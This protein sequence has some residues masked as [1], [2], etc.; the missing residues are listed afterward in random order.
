M[1][2]KQFGKNVAFVLY[3][4]ANRDDGYVLGS[5]RGVHTIKEKD[6]LVSH[7]KTRYYVDET[8]PGDFSE[9]E[10]AKVKEGMSV[11]AIKGVFN[12][13]PFD[14][15]VDEH[16]LFVDYITS[17]K[18]E[19]FIILK[20]D[21]DMIKRAVQ[22]FG[23]G[24]DSATVARMPDVTRAMR[25][26]EILE[27]NKSDVYDITN[28]TRVPSIDMIDD[29]AR[30]AL[31]PALPVK[32]DNHTPIEVIEFGNSYDG[33]GDANYYVVEFDNGDGTSSLK[34]DVAVFWTKQ[35]VQD[36]DKDQSYEQLDQILRT[37]QLS[38]RFIRFPLSGEDSLASMIG[39]KNSDSNA[40]RRWIGQ[41]MH[42]FIKAN[43]D[44]KAVHIWIQGSLT[45][46][47]YSKPGKAGQQ[48]FLR[49]VKITHER[50][51]K[52]FGQAARKEVFD[53][54]TRSTPSTYN[55][56]T[57]SVADGDDLLEDAYTNMALI[58]RQF[59][60]D[61][62][63]WGREYISLECWDVLIA[64]NKTSHLWD[65]WKA[66]LKLQWF[67]GEDVSDENGM[68]MSIA[69]LAVPLSWRKDVSQSL[70]VDLL[71][72]RLV[73][74]HA[75]E[76]DSFKKDPYLNDNNEVSTSVFL[77][78]AYL[79]SLMYNEYVI[80][81]DGELVWTRKNQC[82]LINLPNDTIRIVHKI[83]PFTGMY[84]PTKAELKVH[85]K[86]RSSSG[87]IS[88]PS[89]FEMM[90]QA[91]VSQFVTVA[92]LLPHVQVGSSLSKSITEGTVLAPSGAGKTSYV[93]GLAFYEM[94]KA[95]IDA[96]VTALNRPEVYE[97]V[98][99]SNKFRETGLNYLRS[100]KR[101]TYLHR[102]GAMLSSDHNLL[103][104][105]LFGNDSRTLVLPVL[106]PSKLVKAFRKLGD[107]K[108][109][110]LSVAVTK[111]IYNEA[112]ILMM[113]DR[114][115]TTLFVPMSPL[116][117]MF[118]ISVHELV[119]SDFDYGYIQ[120]GYGF[121]AFPVQRTFYGADTDEENQAGNLKAT[122]STI[123]ATKERGFRH[124]YE[125]VG[126]PLGPHIRDPNQFGGNTVVFVAEWISPMNGHAGLTS[127]CYRE[128]YRP[129]RRGTD[130]KR[131]AEL[132]SVKASG[133]AL[134]ALS[135][136]WPIVLEY[137][138]EIFLRSDG[139]LSPFA[140]NTL[141]PVPKGVFHTQEE[142]N[143]AAKFTDYQYNT[144][145]PS[146]ITVFELCVEN[147]F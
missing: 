25:N 53:L 73:L 84:M 133:H 58:H 33:R 83:I 82:V 87:N 18:G 144:A 101:T 99:S 17:L 28:V 86:L 118:P 8:S 126:R 137:C 121:V 71:I 59:H 74:S 106:P 52:M 34:K 57:V 69:V 12:D 47:V 16:R 102:Y 113:N 107:K 55:D 20:H 146:L 9:E 10:R 100:S 35:N 43:S 11:H 120:Q 77:A 49:N 1:F 19:K 128:A 26:G 22:S 110:E 136:P 79:I 90:H 75:N 51:V 89:D 145:W 44:V 46:P 139:I 27:V 6:F 60:D 13:K 96:K 115:T 135:A 132:G 67:N 88:Q 104:L 141:E 130:A 72:G 127:L 131:L 122:Y 40:P 123:N 147:I 4:K 48:K 114:I 76:L 7:R 41:I 31:V 94:R 2:K 97:R 54:S 64:Q 93:Y 42:E 116:V 38:K 15:S 37:Q 134:A 125:E 111:Q 50:L 39:K 95:S 61:G 24:I 109:S 91:A 14:N 30:S 29:N 119:E 32:F 117:R 36:D 3:P 62:M 56:G 92:Q 70:E 45:F 68:I 5:T 98:V 85:S 63:W 108:V 105:E 124:F 143:V 81:I 140:F 80:I 103:S 65:D 21:D 129:G 78:I 112:N 23:D 138:Y 142:Y 66:T